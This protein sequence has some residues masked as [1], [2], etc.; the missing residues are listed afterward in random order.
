[1]KSSDEESHRVKTIIP[2]TLQELEDVLFEST[3]E[4]NSPWLFRGVKSCYTDENGLAEILSSFQVYCKNR[5]M[6]SLDLLQLEC[7]LL[8]SF[9]KYA[10]SPKIPSEHSSGFVWQLLALAE[11]HSIPTRII[12]FSH[13]PYIALHFATV[14]DMDKPGEIWMVNPIICHNMNERVKEFLKKTNVMGRGKVLTGSQFDQFL[15]LT[16]QM[17][18][19]DP[20]KALVILQEVLG[21]GV[22]F[23]EPPQR[24]VRAVTQEHVFAILGNTSANLG[25]FFRRCKG[26]VARRIYLSP[27]LK[28]IARRKID[29][30]G[31]N[32]R[33]VMGG[34]DG[35][36]QWLR[37][38]Y[39]VSETIQIPCSV[40][41]TPFCKMSR[42]HMEKEEEKNFHRAKRRKLSM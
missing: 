38:Y 12:N 3:S 6:S 18:L 29:I 19:E 27:N 40:R 20:S 1:M 16:P 33:S 13:N 42:G 4:A 26:D 21:D 11:H 35:L 8:R 7:G 41:K 39:K 34:L 2:K 14:N 37:R 32:E 31:I 10:N 22:V 17:S 23:I 25:Q 36:A 28:K 5:S 15:Q 9:F 30:V 24:H